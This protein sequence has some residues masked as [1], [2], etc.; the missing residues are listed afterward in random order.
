MVDYTKSTGSSGTMMIRDTGTAVEFWLNANNSQ[1][2]NHQLPWGYTVNGV[3]NNNREYDY[4][5][6][7]GWERLGSW[8]VAYDQT[9]TFR[10][11]DTGTSGLGGPTTLSAFINRASAPSAPSKPI[12]SEITA[13]SMRVRWTAG[14]SN[15]A[16]INLYQVARNTSNTTSGATLFSVDT[17]HVFTGLAPGT[18]YYWW[19]RTRNSQGYSSWSPVAYASTI[20]VGD[21]PDQPVLSD[22]T[23][24]S[25]VVSFTDNDNGGSPILERRITYNTVNTA[26]GAPTVLYSGVMT[27][28]SLQPATTYYVWARVRNA[29]GWSPYSPVASIMT[30]AGARINVN[31]VW[32][33]AIP[34]VK[35][36]G[37]WKIAQP[38]SRIAGLWKKTE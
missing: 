18:R 25:F 26:V 1:T 22:A 34:Y 5:A 12:I 13:N 11:F 3:T 38:Y 8:G 10:L 14:S 32:K 9:V 27:I 37:V 35:V 15:G 33:R 2:F 28:G 29:A 6:G 24:T 4:K 36:S 19:A 16:S 7:S 31:G 30:V 21:A 23:Q 20:S 17:D